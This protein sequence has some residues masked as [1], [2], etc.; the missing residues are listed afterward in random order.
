MKHIRNLSGGASW[1][2]ESAERY[3]TCVVHAKPG[4]RHRRVKKNCCYRPLLAPVPLQ[5]RG[6]QVRDCSSTDAGWRRQR[7]TEAQGRST[8]IIS[9]IKWI[10]T[11]RLSIKNSLS[12]GQATP[13]RGAGQQMM[14]SD[15][16]VQ[17]RFNVTEGL[18]IHFAKVNSRTNPSTYHSY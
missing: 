4:R 14:F 18:Q 15:V 5:I 8:K 3:P 11:S 6:I 12:L 1:R 2:V 13:H 7:R 9:M 10:R 16:A 17:V